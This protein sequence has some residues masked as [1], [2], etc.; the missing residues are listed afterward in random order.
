MVRSLTVAVLVLCLPASPRG[1]AAQRLADGVIALSG[2]ASLVVARAVQVRPE[3]SVRATSS[4]QFKSLAGAA[5]AE[6]LRSAASPAT[7]PVTLGSGATLLMPPPAPLSAGARAAAGPARRFEGL[8]AA[9]RAEALRAAGAAATAAPADVPFQL[10]PNAPATTRGCLNTGFITGT[11]GFSN[12]INI[13][14]QGWVAVFVRGGTPTTRFMVQLQVHDFDQSASPYELKLPGG[15]T[16]SVPA[17]PGKESQDIVVIVTLSAP[18]NAGSA[19]ALVNLSRPGAT[20]S[21]IG[22]EVTPM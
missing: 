13:G 21:F 14:K 10:T 7:A 19:M 11:D 17:Q 15:T 12:R 5:R 2:G 4:P 3:A 22:A 6:A 8:P 9:V 1:A 20:S 18:L 16:M